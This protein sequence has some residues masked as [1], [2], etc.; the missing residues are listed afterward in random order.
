MQKKFI[1][2]SHPLNGNMPVY[3]DTTA[4]KF[5]VLNTVEKNGFAELEVTMVLH[6]GT[7]VDAPSHIFSNAKSIDRFPLDKFIGQAIV[8]RCQ[9]KKEI[10]V[11]HLQ[12]F[13]NTIAQID[14][15]LF[16]TGWQDKWN[17]DGYLDNCPIPN[18]EA[19][20][21]LAQFDLKG[22]GIDS[23]SLDNVT[24]AEHLA[25]EI[26]PNHHIFLKK[27]ILLIENLTNLNKLPRGTF[28]FYCLPLNIEHADGSPV[29]AMALINGKSGG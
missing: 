18:R 23:F 5:E 1:D 6:S 9:G 22:L 2:L 12:P 26:L 17:T 16:Y 14:F 3:P 8:I 25:S 29:R 7:H 4:P 15:I 21:W 11:K 20:I 10:T 28:S 24:P 19:A 13:E 27:E